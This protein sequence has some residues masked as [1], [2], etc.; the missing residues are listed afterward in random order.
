MIQ[1]VTAG[2]AIAVVVLAVGLRAPASARADGP[3]KDEDTQ[4]KEEMKRI[5][6]KAICAALAKY[7]YAATTSD[8]TNRCLLGYVR[9]PNTTDTCQELWAQTDAKEKVKG[10]VG[11][12]RILTCSKCEDRPGT[13]TCGTDTTVSYTEKQNIKADD[14]LHTVEIKQP[15]FMTM[16]YTGSI[17]RAVPT[18]T[19]GT[20]YEDD[21]A[22]VTG[23]ATMDYTFV[24]VSLKYPY[25][26]DGESHEAG[27][28]A[29]KITHAG[30]TWAGTTPIGRSC[31]DS[32]TKYAGAPRTEKAPECPPTTDAASDR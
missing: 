17:K 21:G 11:K 1:R 6:A 13:Q 15:V 26:F 12:P 5:H 8:I 14:G 19:L 7:A 28:F 16:K 4:K 29:C 22:L 32:S 30:E 10:Y 20:G 31:G 25:H 18:S 2:P 27:T 9:V 23:I 24:E 3:L